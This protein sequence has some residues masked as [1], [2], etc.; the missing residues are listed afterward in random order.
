MKKKKTKKHRPS[1]REDK[2][3]RSIPENTVGIRRKKR[4]LLV[5][6]GMGVEKKKPIG[7]QR[8]PRVQG[9]AGNIGA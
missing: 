7:D 9:K 2:S 5:G 4:E 8:A 1:K 6:K 3:A